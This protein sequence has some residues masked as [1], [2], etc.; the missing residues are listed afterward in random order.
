MN[1][2]KKA[3]TGITKGLMRA[4]SCL[5]LKFHYAWAG[6]FAWVLKD[7][8]HY[9]RDVVV[10]NISRSFPGMP[11]H[12]LRTVTREFYNHFGEVLAEA[13]WFGGCRRPQRL[14][15]QNL[16]EFTN[17]DEFLRAAS[18]MPG[19][20]LLASHFGNW[21]LIGGC[22]AADRSHGEFLDPQFDVNKIVVVHKPLNS[23]MWEEI[24]KTNRCAPALLY[25]H[26][27][28]VGTTS[29]LRHA[30]SHRKDGYIYVFP[31]DQCPY[32]NAVAE[33]DVD[34]LSQKT[35]TMLGPANLAHKLGFSVVYMSLN[36]VR[37]GHYEWSFKEICHDAS[38]SEPL[39]IMKEYY[40]LLENDINLNPSNYLWTHKRWKQKSKS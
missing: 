13:I 18:G 25:G 21:E 27:N 35:R 14:Y 28:Y 23:E 38:L 5:P 26:V 6:F 4:L 9:R 39:D 22:I 20:V 24:M 40:R 29:I 15:N 34:F 11:Y 33:A 37:R 7:L 19:V 32:K 36:R 30:V 31:A 16:L 3:M 17:L 2:F 1:A 10:T 8:V 12:R